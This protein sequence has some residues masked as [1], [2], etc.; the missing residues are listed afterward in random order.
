MFS[1]STETLHGCTVSARGIKQGIST[2]LAFPTH[3]LCSQGCIPTT[4]EMLWPFDYPWQPGLLQ[5]C[6]MFYLKNFLLSQATQTPAVCCKARGTLQI[7]WGFTQN[8]L[9]TPSWF[10]QQSSDTSAQLAQTDRAC[11]ATRVGTWGCPRHFTS[12][13]LPKKAYCTQLHGDP[14]HLT[15][16]WTQFQALKLPEKWTFGRRTVDTTSQTTSFCLTY[17]LSDK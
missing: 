12:V 9:V 1:N 11:L 15:A 7:T 6:G 14:G 16:N 2:H 13:S 10:P 8:L 3:R 4:T 17:V 5:I